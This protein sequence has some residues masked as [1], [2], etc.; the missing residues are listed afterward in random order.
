MKTYKLTF[1]IAR[2]FAVGFDLASPTLNKCLCLD[3]N[4][5]CFIIRYWGKGNNLIGFKNY[6]VNDM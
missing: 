2:R 1:A 6:W 3:I 5:G 4:I